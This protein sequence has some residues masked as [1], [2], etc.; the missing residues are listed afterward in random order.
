MHLRVH[1]VPLEERYVPLHIDGGNWV[2]S[3]KMKEEYL[4]ISELQR[5]GTIPRTKDAIE[6]RLGDVGLSEYFDSDPNYPGIVDGEIRDIYVYS[7]FNRHAAHNSSI[8]RELVERLVSYDPEQITYLA[9]LVVAYEDLAAL[10]QCSEGLFHVRIPPSQALY[11]GLLSSLSA[12][13]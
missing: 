8:A 7:Y 1:T 3:D 4:I 9:E 6:R 13:L 12:P 2:F 10:L 5:E 11:Q